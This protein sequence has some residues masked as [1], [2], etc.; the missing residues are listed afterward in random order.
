MEDLYLSLNKG[1]YKIDATPAPAEIS[2]E[3]IAS[4]SLLS[5]FNQVINVLQSGKTQFTNV[6]AGYILGLDKGTAKFYIGDSTN[7]LNWTG[8]SLTIAGSITATTITGGT[9]QTATSGQRIRIVSAVGATPTQAANSLMLIDSSNNDLLDFGSTSGVI[10]TISPYSDVIGLNIIDNVGVTLT[11]NLATISISETAS[12]GKALSVTNSGTGATLYV[13]PTA[14]A[15]GL[16]VEDSGA[17]ASTA[18]LVR[19]TSSKAPTAVK[20]IKSNA[21]GYPLWIDQQSSTSSYQCVYITNASPS[22]GLYVDQN[23]AATAGAIGLYVNQRKTQIAALSLQG[24]VSST[25]FYKL[26]DLQTFALWA[27]DGTTPNG[28]LG[29]NIG[30]W[31]IGGD[32]GKPY[33]CTGTTNWTVF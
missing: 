14:S 23:N 29:G 22:I 13:S 15:I 4:G 20:I 30:D 33:Y 3:Q 24:T 9:F 17:T 18:D 21:T 10:M 8:S 31:C 6:D 25:H 27:S 32:S 28:N 5:S 26:A 16:Q 1:L 19:V 12:S 2:P 11:N 7:Y